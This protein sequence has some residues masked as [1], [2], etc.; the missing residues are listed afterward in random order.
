MKMLLAALLIATV[1]LPAVAQDFDNQ[2]IPACT[3]SELNQLGSIVGDLTTLFLNAVETDNLTTYHN[4]QVQ[5]W[6]DYHGRFPDCAVS[7]NLQELFAPVIDEL[8]IAKALRSAGRE[9]E[10]DLHFDIAMQHVRQLQRGLHETAGTSI[11]NS[12]S[13]S[14]D[15][16]LQYTG[17][18]HDVTQP[19]TLAV[20]LYIARV[21]YT[22]NERGYISIRV[23]NTDGEMVESYLGG[24]V[25]NGSHASTFT[26]HARDIG[27]YAIEVGGAYVTYWRIRIEKTG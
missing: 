24:L 13:Q 17:S 23:Y 18:G 14:N 16:G 15:Q 9:H 22:L 27:E 12:Q 20:G 21:N 25:D 8:L 7:R 2:P 1:V 19:F 11:P 3:V 6:Q 5:Y 26:I 4:A 10:G